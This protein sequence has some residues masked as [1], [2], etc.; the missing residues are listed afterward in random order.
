MLVSRSHSLTTAQ[1]NALRD[2][3]LAAKSEIEQRIHGNNQ[4]GLSS[5][6]RDET[7]ELSP[8]D[9]HPGDLGTELFVRGK[10]IALLEQ[11]ELHLER[12][13]AALSAIDEGSYGE[14]AVCHAPIPLE[15]LE[16]LPDTIYCIQ[17]SPRQQ[18]STDRPVEEEVLRQPFGRTSLDE[19]DA[20]KG[21]DGE[22]SWQIV[23][24]WGN[25]TSPAFSENRDVEDYEH[26]GIEAE[27]HDGYVEAI[28]SFLATDITGRQAY[29][30]RNREYNHY[31][32][33]GE[34]DHAL[35]NDDTALF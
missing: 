26:I 16:A 32:D 25:S 7:S 28:E 12:V 3:L 33:S 8:I 13:I 10:D 34:G 6:L 20:V 29:I 9:N 4:Y 14:C 31:M 23:E 24:Q 21:F 30:V 1:L 2:Q 27:E 22:D 18:V 19:H 5:S 35:E 15:R 11:E 17:H